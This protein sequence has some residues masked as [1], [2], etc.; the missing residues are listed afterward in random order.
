[1]QENSTTGKHTTNMET[2]NENM[3]F[4]EDVEIGKTG[5]S[6]D[7]SRDTGCS[8]SRELSV[9]GPLPSK[10]SEECAPKRRYSNSSSNVSIHSNVSN[11]AMSTHEGL[12]KRLGIKGAS[13]LKKRTANSSQGP[14]SV[15]SKTG[16][17]GSIRT[18]ST[19]GSS[20]SG[21]YQP[22]RGTPRHVWY[23]RWLFLTLLCMVAASLGYLTYSSLTNNE[24]YLAECVFIKVAEHAI[25][26]ISTNQKN[27]KLGMDSIG[28]VIGE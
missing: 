3:G 7:S 20:A 17:T 25:V 28:G 12:S 9:V 1:M 6:E 5:S 21:K 2:T 24:T 16:V 23:S 11:N 19:G 8:G 27:K 10:T 26:S 18:S 22:H 14:K 4:L 15:T 13:I